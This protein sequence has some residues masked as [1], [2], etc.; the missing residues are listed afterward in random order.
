MLRSPDSLALRSEVKVINPCPGSVV[1][2][3]VTELHTVSMS[4]TPCLYPMHLSQSYI[5]VS[6]ITLGETCREGNRFYTIRKVL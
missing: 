1:S 3:E 6:H 4:L 5:Q 2:L